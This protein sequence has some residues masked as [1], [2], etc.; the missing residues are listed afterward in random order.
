MSFNKFLLH[1]EKRIRN[2]EKEKGNERSERRDLGTIYT[3]KPIVD[4][5]VMNVL[6]LYLED[7]FNFP[8]IL[9]NNSFLE[10]FHQEL[11]KNKYLQKK[12]IQKLQNIRILDPACGSGRFLISIA[13]YLFNLFKLLN[14]ELTD[15]QLKKNIVEKNLYGIEI[16]TTAHLITKLRLISWVISGSEEK[17][18]LPP[19]NFEEIDLEGINQM[20][21][22]LD[23]N[24][25]LFNLDFLLEF[26]SNKFDLIIGNPPYVENKKISNLKFKHDLKRKFKSAYRLFDLSIVFIEKA[27]E[28]LKEDHAYLSMITINKF[29]SADYGIYIRELLVNN[30][31]LKE[32]INISSLPIFGKT[33]V[34]PIIITLK[35]RIPRANHT[36]LIKIYKEINEFNEDSHVESQILPQKLI[37]KVPAF[38]FP[39]FGQIDLMNYLFSKFKSFTDVIK[40][41][42][43]T[44]RPYGFIN[45]SKHLNKINISDEYSEKDLI[46]IGTGNIGKYHI[47][48][49][50][51]IKIAKKNIPLSY[52]KYQNEFENIWEIL[53]NQKLIFREIAK[54]LTWI[55]DP[56]I[57][58]NV[59]GLYF[60]NIPSFTQNKLFSL[61]TI[62]NSKLM[63]KIFKTLFSS[64]HMAGGYL[65]FNGSFIKKLPLP[66]EFPLSLSFCGKYLQILSQLNY[67]FNSKYTEGKSDL[68]ALK[69]KF[70]EEIISLIQF[71]N[72]LGNSMVNLLYLDDLYLEHN[73]DYYLLRELL[74]SKENLNTIP[75]KYLFPRYKID[76]YNTYTLDELES[77]INKIRAHSEFISNNELLIKQINE[78]INKAILL[79]N[80]YG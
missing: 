37:K 8:K 21:A 3:P 26:E 23:I 71:F 62:M 31:E 45:W 36:I 63:N 60:V 38:V 14:L 77:I 69:E 50:K 11:S 70:Q 79:K 22:G 65:R 68:I 17:I 33:A 27:L 24:F 19:I 78:I 6:R 12:Y 76:K 39:I 15:Y 46:L 9:N 48:F 49:D 56:G 34:Y 54:D 58:T 64:L 51:Y 55:Y 53:K 16:E 29:L 59:T 61:L 73:I 10:M 5:I 1:L 42:K 44:Y 18:N 4:Y 7:V 75:F 72:N 74:Y 41:F 32:I 30:T 67:D 25:N 20:I 80:K 40:D 66:Q 13:E 43:I 47:K 28:L 2:F 52:F 35:N 57:Y